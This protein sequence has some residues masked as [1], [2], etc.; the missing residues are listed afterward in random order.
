MPDERE[1][2]TGKA[3]TVPGRRRKAPT[4][5][6]KPVSSSTDAGETG[7]ASPER[8][9]VDMPGGDGPTTSAAAKTSAPDRT[10]WDPP[11]QPAA[12]VEEPGPTIAAGDQP[13]MAANA[14]PTP[15]REAAPDE[16]LQDRASPKPMPQEQMP[17]APAPQPG[18]RTTTAGLLVPALVAAVVGFAFGALG[19]SFL[20]RPE[21]IDLVARTRLSAL[22][23][24]LARRAAQPA[25][26]AVDPGLD[27]RLKAV[28]AALASPPP[29]APSAP[30]PALAE[31]LARLESDLARVVAARPAAPAGDLEPLAARLTAAEERLAATGTA[32]SAVDTRVTELA[33][34]STARLD[35]LGQKM[36]AVEQ[37]LTG[38]TERLAGLDG[39]VG[40]LA[41]RQSAGTAASVF[42]ASH[43]LGTAFE[44]GAAF[45]TELA[46][47]ESLGLPAAKLA[48]LKAV[49]ESGVAPPRAL[50]DLFAADA[51][52]I[53]AFGTPS[54]PAEGGVRGWLQS[55]SSS[56]VRSR[57]VGTVTGDDPASIVARVQ[58][59]LARGDVE[60][61]WAEWVK[62]PDGARS[63]APRFAMLAEARVAAGKALAEVQRD[64]LALIRKP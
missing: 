58:A 38:V 55:L 15:D 56:L 11:A 3:E 60:T 29:A 64:A 59:A 22:D 49:A 51:A 20:P 42:A 36:T 2:G 46:A 4:I 57:P 40:D 63:L 8:A 23:A 12:P 27:Q 14:S 5:D 47:L 6:L 39:R 45:P 61:A 43:A 26:A 48:P 30:D 32:A 52:R 53:A 54:Q 33:A 1:S 44:R 62:L 37:R 21:G 16:A 7:A 18:A 9:Q 41:G 24:E 19:S 35:D 10:V 31:R 13:G 28:E 50:A 17:D 25:P 34:A